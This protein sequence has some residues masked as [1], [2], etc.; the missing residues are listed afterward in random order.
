MLGWDQDDS[1]KSMPR[2]FMQNFW[3]CIWRELWVT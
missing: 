3:F 1:T 2:H